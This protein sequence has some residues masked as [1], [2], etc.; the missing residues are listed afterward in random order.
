MRRCN[1]RMAARASGTASAALTNVAAA[2]MT[3]HA[4]RFVFRELVVSELGRLRRVCRGF[5]SKGKGNPRL[6]FIAVFRTHRC[7]SHCCRIAAEPDESITHLKMRIRFF[8][9]VHLVRVKTGKRSLWNMFDDANLIKR[10]QTH[11][12]DGC[13]RR[14]DYAA[15]FLKKTA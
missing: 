4:R 8:R 9:C 14:D 11:T 5:G 12:P 7:Q 6:S 13:K 15:P 10:N 3:P 2:A 1:S